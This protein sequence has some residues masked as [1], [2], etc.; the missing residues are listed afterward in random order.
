MSQKLSPGDNAGARVVIELDPYGM[1]KNSISWSFGAPK[2][3]GNVCCTP[4]SLNAAIELVLSAFG[5]VKY[6]RLLSG[7][8]AIV[9]GIAIGMFGGNPGERFTAFPC[10]SKASTVEP[11]RVVP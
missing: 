7:S 1:R 6:K 11:A 2:C 10:S 4:W 8:N 5:S 3:P 9:F